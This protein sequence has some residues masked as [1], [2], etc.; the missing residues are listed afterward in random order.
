MYLQKNKWSTAKK[1]VYND[2]RYDSGFE[3]KHAQD[4]DLMQKAGEIKSWEPQIT[5][6]LICNGYKI[7]TY[8]IDFVVYNND[9]SVELVETKGI[10]SQLWKYKW[11]ILETMVMS[12]DDYLKD[13]FGDVEIK[14]SLVKQKSNWSMHKI[15]KI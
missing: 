10:A 11:K 12:G 1:Q 8:K 3:A 15:K 2:Y 14:M 5:L 6:D 13:K 7:G 4:L 9:D